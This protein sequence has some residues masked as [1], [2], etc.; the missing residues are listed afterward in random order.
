[1]ARCQL[2]QAALLSLFV[3]PAVAQTSYEV[4]PVASIEID[5]R[6][7]DAIWQTSRVI[8]LTQQAPRAGQPTPYVT[9][10]R[11]AANANNLYFAFEC[12]DPEPGRI[13]THTMQRD[14]DITGDDFVSIVLD[15]YGD[16]R[17]GYLF[18][19]NAS[20]ARVDGLVA[21]AETPSLNWD[22]IWDARTQRTA[23]GWTAEIAIPARSL[24]FTPGLAQWGA[25]FER[26]IP[27]DRTFLRWTSPTLDSFFYDLSRGG[28][29]NGLSELRQ[30]VGLEISP[31]AV[32]RMRATFGDGSRSFQG[33]PGVD[34]T[35]RITPQ[36]AAVFT[37][38]TD[39]AETEVDTRQINTS[40]FDLFFPER[41]SFFLEGSNQ[42]QFGLGLEGQFIP[43]FSRRIGLFGGEQ[44][45]INA[46]VKLNGRSGKWNIG[47]I[48]VS[49]RDTT[50]RS[51]RAIPG[52]NLFASRISYDV[53]RKFRVGTIVT[54]GSPDGV[55]SNTL[56]GVDGVWRTSEFLTNKNLFVGGWMALSRGDRRVGTDAA[57]SRLGYGFKIDY[58]NDRWDCFVALNQFGE[59]LDPSLGFLPRP[60][61]RRYQAQCEF[62]PRPRKDGPFGFIR[63]EFMDHRY[64]R[65]TN[66][67]GQLESH[68]FYWA[69]VQLQFET[70]DR[71]NLSFAPEYQF[72]PVDFN[73]S[74]V[75]VPT[76]EYSYLRW[77][78]EFVTSNHRPFE[79]AAFFTSG[80]YYG[81]R[82]TQTI[83]YLQY[84]Q[85]KGR[86]QSGLTVYTNFGKLPQGNFVQ[87][88]WQWNATYAFSSY[89]SLTNFLQYDT[90]SHNLGNNMR[91]RY[92]LKPG[93]DLFVVWNRGWKSA[94]IDRNDLGLLP[95]S[96]LVAI[97]LRWTFR[98]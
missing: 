97:K 62:R 49:L 63:Q 27:R 90:D 45:P 10:V 89:V 14:G 74:G 39:F 21:G 15:T 42:Y 44:I 93:N 60:G 69:P 91:L 37:A 23:T 50:L 64:L 56:A 3:L 65:V 59:G 85:P 66:A 22:G 48:D 32:G 58:P 25:N 1:L 72:T 61:V 40:R 76:G 20:A 34:V 75:R 24:N 31:Y 7:D 53:T 5:G 88:L 38:N 16:R 26:G 41:R 28:T 29:L 68:Q 2:S 18:R 30:G 13:A 83:A 4:A 81:G 95:E 11:I 67:R 77:R 19:V 8:E 71:L 86:W 96:E 80:G 46:G 51:G 70:G 78:A 9:R 52:T 73:I 35:Y 82:L 33:T 94:S 98:R 36:L 57:A 55:R 92:T 84:T 17:T 79:G 47:L 43:F 54:R 6:L 12:I 87:R